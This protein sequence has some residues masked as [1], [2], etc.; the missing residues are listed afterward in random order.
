MKS[1]MFFAKMRSFVFSLKACPLGSFP[2]LGGSIIKVI[3]TI[4]RLYRTYKPLQYFSAISLI[5][6]LLSAVFFVPIFSEYLKTGL[7]LRF[8][9][10]IVCCFTTL[11]AIISFFCGLVLSTI[12]QK[13]RQDFE[14]ELI[15]LKNEKNKNEQ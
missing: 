7:V 11:A 10:L 15:R 4:I 5:L 2:K 3:R 1:K 9:T 6:I 8:P 13:N 14:M 12:Q